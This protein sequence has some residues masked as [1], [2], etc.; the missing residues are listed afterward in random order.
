MKYCRVCG[1][2]DGM[3]GQSLR[4]PCSGWNCVCKVYQSEDNLE[5]LESLVDKIQ[6]R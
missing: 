6:N 5:Y 1:H 2:Y 3:H 4:L